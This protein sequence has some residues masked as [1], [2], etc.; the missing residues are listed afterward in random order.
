MTTNTARAY[1]SATAPYR[2]TVNQLL[3]TPRVFRRPQ[4]RQPRVFFFGF[5]WMFFYAF[6]VALFWF[7]VLS[8]TVSWD[9][10]V[11]IGVGVW[12]LGLV[13]VRAIKARR[14]RRHREATA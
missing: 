8:F 4:R 5:G 7:T 9:V 11:V 1:R 12:F 6:M 3:L 14:E 13:S 2:D 10:M